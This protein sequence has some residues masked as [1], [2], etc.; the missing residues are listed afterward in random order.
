[1]DIDNH[2]H[3][4]TA[5]NCLKNSSILVLLSGMHHLQGNTHNYVVSCMPLQVWQWIWL[6]LQGCGPAGVHG[7]Q[8]TVNLREWILCLD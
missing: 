6:Q 4:E 5:L 8:V 2:P 1:L 3:L 7:F